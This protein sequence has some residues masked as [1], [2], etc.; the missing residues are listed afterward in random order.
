MCSIFI[1]TYNDDKHRYDN[2][3]Y[4]EDIKIFRKIHCK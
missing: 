2:G 3:V 4:S 1:I